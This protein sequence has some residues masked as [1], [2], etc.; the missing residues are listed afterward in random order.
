MAQR[1]SRSGSNVYLAD[2]HGRAIARHEEADPSLA[3]PP[4]PDGWDRALAA[5]R[6]V[7][8]GRHL[9]AFE[10]VEQLGWWVAVER[11]QRVALAGVREGRDLAFVLLLLVVP[12]AVIGG[13]VTARRISRPLDTLA[14]AV[15][16][17]T[18]GNPAAPL[19]SSTIGEVARLS[20]AFAEMRDRL[21]ARTRESERLAAELLA[22]AE[23]LS[24][25]DRRKDEF[26]A[27]LAH[28][29]R[30]PLGAIANSAW[31]L[32]ESDAS[33]PLTDRAVAVIQRQ[34]QHLVR[35][36]D[37]L[38]D[39]S[40]ITRGK[41]ELRRER[42]DLADVVRHTVEAIRPLMEARDHT[43]TVDLPAEP[44]P[45][46]ADPTRLEQVL[47]NLLRNSAKFTD[48]GGRIGV[49]VHREDGAA[50]LS[51]RDNGAG[52]APDLLPRVFDLFTQ[53][54]QGIDRAGAGLGIGLTLVRN[55]VEMHGGRIEAHSQGAGA[56]CTMQ[57]RLPLAGMKND[58][59]RMT[60]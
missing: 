48:P 55:L 16:E 23:A 49:Q 28:E 7:G 6:R 9:A 36:V 57:V 8:V 12:L 19:D 3:G 26:L 33:Q 5:G 39:V 1:I 44:L 32:A 15:G 41:V 21:A 47:G 11:P 51:V 52:I 42:I 20:A 22:R 31:V 27:M 25:S 53:G 40:R 50:I 38:L 60:K 34:I 56:G 43:L 37:D 58:E 18:A 17:L 29:L 10:P 59:S 30:N 35:L 24:D 14:S 13:I 45:L 46:D 4:L 54:Q 2:G